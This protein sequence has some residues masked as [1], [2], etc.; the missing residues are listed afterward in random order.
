MRIR[1]IIEC[2]K[3]ESGF[4]FYDESTHGIWILGHHNVCL[5]FCYFVILDLFI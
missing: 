3:F 2:N 4:D 1:P 5:H